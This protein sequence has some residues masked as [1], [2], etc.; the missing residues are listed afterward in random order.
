MQEQ[1][2]NGPRATGGHLRREVHPHQHD[3]KQR[4]N[5]KNNVYVDS[6]TKSRNDWALD[7]E[8]KLLVTW[9]F[10]EQG[11]DIVRTHGLCELI[12]RG[13]RIVGDQAAA[14]PHDPLLWLSRR[15]IFHM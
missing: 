15:D 13:N 3:A 9:L 14:I 6:G 5:K 2:G 1:I 7:Q 4:D 12:V 11:R 8:D 10:S